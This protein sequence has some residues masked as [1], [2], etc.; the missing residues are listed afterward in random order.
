MMNHKS[1]FAIIAI[2]MVICPIVAFADSADV[3]SDCG[4]LYAWITDVGIGSM[5]W[6]TLS[7]SGHY[8]RLVVK[9]SE[10]YQF[11][12]L[13]IIG[14][15]EE[16]VERK[17]LSH[18]EF[19]FDEFKSNRE[20]SRIDI[21]TWIDYNTVEIAVARKPFLLHFERDLSKSVVEELPLK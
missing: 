20:T 18:Y 10:V 4:D 21:G 7:D 19:P 8:F 11:L 1:F 15:D 12:Y 14:T 6:D 17:V 13:E 2:C 5:V 16:G 9:T 3:Y